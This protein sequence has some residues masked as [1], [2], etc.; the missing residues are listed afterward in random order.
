MDPPRIPWSRLRPA[1]L[2]RPPERLVL[3]LTGLPMRVLDR[4]TAVV[5]LVFVLAGLGAP[6]PGETPEAGAVV[7]SAHRSTIHGTPSDPPPP[8]D[9][10]PVSAPVTTSDRPAAPPS[11]DLRAVVAHFVHPATASDARADLCG[12]N[13]GG[14][15]VC[16]VASDGPDDLFRAAPVDIGSTPDTAVAPTHYRQPAVPLPPRGTLP[17]RAPPTRA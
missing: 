16:V 6:V 7:T 17:T 14:H 5:A 13:R 15:R 8:P 2:C 3:K 10:R 11:G 1:A 4:L 9:G 12:R